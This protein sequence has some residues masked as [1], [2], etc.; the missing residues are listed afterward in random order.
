[1]YI[2]PFIAAA[3]EESVLYS[4]LAILAILIF[5]S[6]GIA[7]LFILHGVVIDKMD[8]GEAGKQS[9]ALIRAKWKDYLKENI[10]F[11]ITI[12]G[13]LAVVAV[14]FLF[15]PLKIL[16]IISLP[17]ALNSILTIFFVVLGVIISM[18]VDLLGTPLYILKMTQL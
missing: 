17:A 16:S 7:N 13:I 3:I 9:T 6:V 18:A 11:I 8:V 2:P 4:V 5:L 10:L 12:G 1:M 14:V 15:L